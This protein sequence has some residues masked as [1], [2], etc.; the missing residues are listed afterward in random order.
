MTHQI[1][2]NI[3]LADSKCF[4]MLLGGTKGDKTNIKIHISE[5]KI[6]HYKSII[7]CTNFIIIL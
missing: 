3:V 2:E 1:K 7:D 4:A 6:G 5:E